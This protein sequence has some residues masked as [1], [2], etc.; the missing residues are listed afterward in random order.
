M[1]APGAGSAAARRWQSLR[2][3]P[4]RT[5]LRTKLITGL[6]ALVIAAVAAISISSVWVLRSYLTSQDDNQ[7]RSVFNN[8]VTTIN[9]ANSSGQAVDLSPGQ[10]VYCPH[11]SNIW[12]GVQEP[13]TPISG[14]SGQGGAAYGGYPQ[15][16]SVPAVPTSQ[17]WAITNEG[18]LTTVPAQ[19]GSDTWRVITEPISYQGPTAHRS[20]AP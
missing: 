5:S 12:F 6:L 7:L 11:T 10:M 3:W 4:N 9:G 8:A 13:G 1:T 14:P 2:D 18:K 20:R 19:S 16:Q 15:A 17:L